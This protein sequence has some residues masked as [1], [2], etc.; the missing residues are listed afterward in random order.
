M[1]LDMYVYSIS[2][3]LIGATNNLVDVDVRKIGRSGVGFDDL[4]LDE[5]DKLPDM[6]KEKYWEAYRK[7]DREAQE[8]G[9]I[10]RSFY[11]WRKFNA[12]H[13]WMQD[14]YVMRGGTGEFNCKT[15][16][17]FMSDINDLQEILDTKSLTPTA[18]FFFGAQEIYE[19]DW[20]SLEEFLNKA[21]D[22][23][24]SGKALY[25]DSWW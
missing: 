20:A 18:G 5:T 19:E 4:P 23:L 13:G 2:E 8:K 1:G 7:A 11:Y 17:L 3:D 16:R 21:V 15:L 6:E 9:V 24:D 12:L 14:L 10:N 22:E 25:Y